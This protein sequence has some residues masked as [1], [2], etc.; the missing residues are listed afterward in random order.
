MS[1]TKKHT[2]Y[3]NW[4][5]E[6]KT[7]IQRT[8]I[9]ASISVNREL[10]GLYWTI[11]KSISEKVNTANWGSSVVEKLS[12]DLKEEFP[13]QKGFSRSN[14]FSMKKWFEFYSQSEIDIEKI[15]Q[16]VGQIPW[17]HNVVIISKSKNIEEAIF[18]SNKTI[19]N[20][21]SRSVLLHQ[22]ELNLYERH[23]KAITNFTETLP[24]PHSELATETLKDPYKFDF[25]TLQEKAIE[26]DIEKQLVKHIT[27][28]LLELGTG[29]S[30]V[31]QQVPVKI[32][33]QDFYIDLLFY[34]I[35]LK[36]YVVVELKAIEFKAEFAGKMN[37]YLSAIDDSLKTEAENPTIGLLL[38]KSKS[39]II[40]EYALRG[41]T[42][43]IGIAEYEISNAIPKEIK[44]ELPTIEEIELATTRAI[45][46]ASDSN[47]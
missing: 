10:M 28:F 47:K 18:Y 1:L 37:L 6:L 43:P 38:C 19:E 26:K 27:S 20:N 32:D 16:L 8:Q 9:K 41:M 12:E 3:I 39:K 23:G 2:E 7:L 22:I 4:V 25:L 46:K 17:G 21:W 5:N 33:N 14:L 36:C 31:G 45:R 13:N 24:T 30:F 42:Q 44:T 34:H 40:A 35:K 15:Q 29:F 11:G